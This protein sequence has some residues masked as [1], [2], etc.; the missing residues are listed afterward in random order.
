MKKSVAEKRK[1]PCPEK[2]RVKR[3]SRE[4]D[5]PKYDVHQGLNDKDLKEDLI[6]HYLNA[7][8]MISV[9]PLVEDRSVPLVDFY[10]HPPLFAF[11]KPV[12]FARVHVFRENGRSRFHDKT[13]INSYKELFGNDD[14]GRFRRIYLTATAGMGKTSFSQRLAITWCQSHKP[15]QNLSSRFKTDEIQAMKQFDLLFLLHLRD[16]QNRKDIDHMIWDLISNN[17]S[18][19]KQYTKIFLEDV[20]HNR[21]C[22]V[23]LDGLD[24]WGYP[25][26]TI[27]I[28]KHH[29]SCT[30][31]TTTRSWKL[32]TLKLTPQQIDRL[33]EISELDEQGSKELESN[34]IRV[35]NEKRDR[36]KPPKDISNFNKLLSSLQIGAIRNIPY[37]KLQLI[38]LW[39]DDRPIG[40][41]KCEIYSNVIELTLERGLKKLKVTQPDPKPLEYFYVPNCIKENNYSFSYIDLLMKLAKL[42][43][44]TLFSK[45]KES[46]LLFDDKIALTYL[47]DQNKQFCMK[48]G[49][50]S[51]TEDSRLVSA[52]KYRLFFHHKSDHEFYAALYISSENTEMDTKKIVAEFCQSVQDIIEISNVFTFL[53]GMNPKAYSVLS[54]Q[55]QDVVER[56]QITH[57]YRQ[58]IAL[59]RRWERDYKRNTMRSYQ[60]MQLACFQESKNENEGISL[61][62]QDII[63]DQNDLTGDDL[64]ALT[65]MTQSNIFNA[66]SLY[67]DTDNMKVDIT[68][69]LQMLEDN[70]PSKLEKFGFDGA[71]GAEV[72]VSTISSSAS[73]L[74]CLQLV[75]INIDSYIPFFTVL[76]ELQAIDIRFIEL[77]HEKLKELYELVEKRNKLIQV[78]LS[79]IIC[80]NHGKSCSDVSLNFS[81]HDL[82]KR[83]ELWIIPL[84]DLHVNTKSLER[85]LFYGAYRE[86][87]A[88][89]SL[90]KDLNGAPALKY[91]E[92][93]VVENSIDE[94]VRTIATLKQLHE[95]QLWNINLGENGLPLSPDMSRLEC[96]DLYR[97][98][99]TTSAWR[100][101]FLESFLKLSKS[102]SVN[103]DLENCSGPSRKE[104]EDLVAELKGYYSLTKPYID[105]YTSFAI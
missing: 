60:S 7:E 72:S 6:V 8:S 42:A 63:L 93:W 65:A 17:L 28:N 70:K 100:R 38:A 46:T 101:F 77:T 79:Y 50:L 54:R 11:F 58:T 80:I 52:K 39:F 73:T 51:Q 57:E 59:P 76:M 27:P 34:A 31:V 82:L 98:S 47:E 97:I 74:K 53:S 94:L 86:Q 24:E 71:T 90:L 103:V 12:Q 48:L 105:Q 61:Q 84:Y 23:I 37:V 20:L 85:C 10:V 67:I 14:D 99:M 96:I 19:S 4:E 9:V 92:L 87:K 49:L 18:R 3:R 36:N 16:Y 15:V 13:E 89:S 25:E 5:Q 30:V 69:F 62:V 88:I 56:D 64:S 66:K 35:L 1:L 95:L 68:S 22:L 44:V 29:N 2:Q 78:R 102:Q 81:H 33:M 75:N 43:F 45:P 26:T 91:L 104:W 41:S 83:L 40:K 21:K 55:L 32:S